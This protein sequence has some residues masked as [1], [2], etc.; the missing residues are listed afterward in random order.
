MLP[1]LLFE[2]PQNIFPILA[3]VI[4]DLQK[5]PKET[6]NFGFANLQ[7]VDDVYSLIFKWTL[8]FLS[9]LPFLQNDLPLSPHHYFRH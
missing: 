9:N 4:T 6:I 2:E 1:P 8:P 7:C 3:E 5:Y